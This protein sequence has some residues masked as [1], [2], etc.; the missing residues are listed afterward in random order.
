M[1]IGHPDWEYHAA[2]YDAPS[3]VWN[4]VGKAVATGTAYTSSIIDMSRF[5]AMEFTFGFTGPATTGRILITLEWF[6][7]A[8]GTYREQF[9]DM[10]V[11]QNGGAIYGK[12]ERRAP[13]LKVTVDN[14]SGTN[15]TLNARI[16]GSYI[17]PAGPRIYSYNPNAA[18]A[19]QYMGGRN[20]IYAYDGS[21][22]GAST[23]TDYPGTW[24]GPATA[25][26]WWEGAA[27][28]LDVWWSPLGDT[29]GLFGYSFPA[30]GPALSV[31]FPVE[32]PKVPLQ[33]NI[34]N[35]NSGSVALTAVLLMGARV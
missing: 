27:N 3:N 9:E 18:A 10:E 32:L 17:V 31:Q 12:M 21:V 35:A 22:A 13:Y 29:T 16:D 30:G 4:L 15:G 26:I 11:A 24:A 25:R 28:T 7:D 5:N 14:N 20:G 2:P 33:L 6:M 1:T 8:A 23:D 19:N 34:D